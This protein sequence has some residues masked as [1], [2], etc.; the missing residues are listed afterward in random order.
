[1]SMSLAR[2][3]TAAPR[4]EPIQFIAPQM[5]I[6]AIDVAGVVHEAEQDGVV[7][8]RIDVA[9]FG[10]HAGWVQV[11]CTAEMVL[12]LVTAWR[13]DAGRTNVD[14]EGEERLAALRHAAVAAYRAYD[15]A[16]GQPAEP[17]RR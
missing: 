1:M 13:E 5:A 17:L 3:T 2:R 14:A 4:T 11:T 8:P 6:H 15:A 12:R 9:P 10:T 7:R 16:R